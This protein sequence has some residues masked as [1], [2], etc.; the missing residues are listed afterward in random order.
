MTDSVQP[1]LIL[2]TRSFAVEVADLVSDIPGFQVTGFVENMDPQRCEDVLEGLPVLWVDEVASMT[3]THKAVC[4][5]STTHRSRFTEQV[6]RQGMSF[7]TIAHPTA[8]ISA[9]STLG[10]GAIVS[11]GAI[12][13]AHT[14][15]GNHVI[16]NRGALVGHHTTIGD[17]VTIGPGANIAGACQIG[18]AAY[19]GIGAVVI[20]HLTVGAHAIVG[21]GAVVTR[22]VPGNVQ[23]VGVPAKIVKEKVKGL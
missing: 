17:H 21:G 3:E 10:E 6:S 2:G 14:H 9:T 19:I 20:D 4:A 5:L 18:D 23:V 22:D 7:A 12:I 15:V 16:V 1:L 8:R 13:A 11:A